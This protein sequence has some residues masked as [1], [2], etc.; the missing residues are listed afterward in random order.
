[1]NLRHKSREK[2]SANTNIKSFIFSSLYVPHEES[3][4]HLR[5]LQI[6]HVTNS[7]SFDA[8]PARPQ[9]H[10]LS[11]PPFL[12]LNCCD[13]VRSAAGPRGRSDQEEPPHPHLKKRV[14]GSERRCDAV[15][16]VL[17]AKVDDRMTDRSCVWHVQDDFEILEKEEQR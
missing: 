4:V 11:A 1:M 8:H 2:S 12:F 7:S 5:A 3:H 14:M 16:D 13:H 15:F 10:A 9:N 17:S 6:N